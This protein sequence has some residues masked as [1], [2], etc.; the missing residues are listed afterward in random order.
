LEHDINNYLV[1]SMYFVLVRMDYCGIIVL[2]VT[3]YIPWLRFAF[4]NDFNVQL[5]YMIVMAVF[6]AMGIAVVIKDEFREPHYRY[7]RFGEFLDARK[8]GSSL[9]SRLA[10]QNITNI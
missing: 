8:Y 3:S 4:Y 6:G 10:Y 7:T 2:T 5:T 9:F 1:I